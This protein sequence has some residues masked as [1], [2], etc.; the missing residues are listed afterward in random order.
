MIAPLI[1][2]CYTIGCAICFAVCGTAGSA[3]RNGF[4]QLS[5]LQGQVEAADDGVGI[6]D[7]N[8]PYISQCLDLGGTVLD[9]LVGHSEA[10]LLHTSLDSVP[11]CQTGCEV[12]VAGEA[13]VGGVQDLVG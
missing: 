4:R 9:L 11:A 2:V 6:I 8:R 3:V 7:S 12:D 5:R 13:E 10:Q 1:A